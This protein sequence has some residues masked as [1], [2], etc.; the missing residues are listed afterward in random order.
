MD[1]FFRWLKANT[2]LILT[3]T[4]S[5]TTV[6][7]Y[8]RQTTLLTQQ[9][10][11]SSWP[12]LEINLQRGFEQGKLTIFKIVI[13]NKG[14]GPAIIEKVV[15]KYKDA[16]ISKWSDFYKRLITPGSMTGHA[17]ALI[18]QTVIMPGESIVFADWEY[19]L[20]F[21]NHAYEYGIFNEVDISICYKSTFDEYWTVSRSGFHTNMERTVRTES[22][23]CSLNSDIYFIE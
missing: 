22:N 4:I 7:I 13:S 19:N 14:N 17:N 5:I 15:V 9:I 2:A 16:P 10:K 6:F 3:L 23:K 12:Y 8:V 1:K 11:A 20:D 21:A 18:S